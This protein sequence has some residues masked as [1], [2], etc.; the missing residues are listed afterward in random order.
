MRRERAC[1]LCLRLR[2][3][4]KF[5]KPK[6]DLIAESG[7][8]ACIVRR[9]LAFGRKLLIEQFKLKHPSGD[10]ADKQALAERRLTAKLPDKLLFDLAQKPAFP[11]AP[12]DVAKS[13]ARQHS[14]MRAKGTKLC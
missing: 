11:R 4:A 9:E 5:T 14:A 13:A 12:I 3:Q 7:K 2:L 6:P 10:S 8:R 1:G